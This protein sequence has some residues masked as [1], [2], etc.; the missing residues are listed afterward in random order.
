MQIPYVSITKFSE[1]KYLLNQ[2]LWEKQKEILESFWNGNYTKGVWALGRRSGKTLMASI[3]V[4]YA[5]CVLSDNYK[6]YLRPNEKYYILTVANTINQ[7]K[8]ALNNVKELI[9]N[10][11]L[12]KDLII[13]ETS[14]SLELVNGA[15]IKSIPT[16]SRSARGMA[17]PLILFDELAYSM[18]TSGNSSGAALF[19][20]LAPGTAQ[21]GHLGKILMLSSPYK[22]EGIFWEI[23]QQGKSGLHKDIQIINLP[24]WEVNTNVSIDF[25]KSEKAR[26]PEMF[27]IEYGAN[28]SQNLSSFLN[29][30]LIDAAINYDRKTLLPQD[31]YLGDYFLSLDP[32]KGSRDAF[33]ACIAHFEDNLLVVDLFYQFKA[34]WG[35]EGQKKQVNIAEVESWILEKHDIYGF[36]KVCL[37]QYN[38]IST[39]QRLSGLLDIEEINWSASSKIKAYSKLIELFN[40]RKIEL[41]PHLE[42]IQQLKNLS[43]FYKPGG[44]WSVSGGTGAAVDDFCSALAGILLISDYDSDFDAIA[45]MTAPVEGESPYAIQNWLSYYS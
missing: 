18:D 5:A 3:S 20:A 38:S 22:Q 28:F 15:I 17:C 24:T 43:V 23:F 26:N 27:A 35:S 1:D 10:S 7:A 2:L 9:K 30:D 32:A 8:L 44:T 34:N 42:S 12:L 45:A 11:P 21:F 39:I 41:Y 16:S 4:C 33:T 40:S 25:L 14:D 13:N 6:K 29:A 19:Q 36:T 37:D 31:C